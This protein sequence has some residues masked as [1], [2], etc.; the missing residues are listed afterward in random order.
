M[1]AVETLQP[2][3]EIRK[4]GEVTDVNF[5]DRTI[6]MIVMP[7]DE[8]TFVEF[9]GRMV[10]EIVAPGSFD[11]IQRRPN[12]V[13]VNYHHQD[14]E[15]RHLLGNAITFHPSRKEGLVSVVRIRKGEYGDMALAAADEGDVG[16]SAGFGVMKGGES[17]PDRGTRRLTRLWL[18]HIALTPTP[19]Y[20]GAH[21]LAVRQADPAPAEVEERPP[22]PNRAS[23]ELQMYLDQYAQIDARYEPRT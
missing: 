10:R 1:T 6:E 4:A 15:L 23:F 9:R 19:A 3:I 11:G 16:A 12:R 2:P 8:P 21:V 18:D 22:T 13:R 20:Q 5:P 14:H 7:Y 17:W